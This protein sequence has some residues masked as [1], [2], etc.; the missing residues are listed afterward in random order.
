[1][2]M[3]GDDIFLSS[4]NFDPLE[5]LYGLKMYGGHGEFEILHVYLSQ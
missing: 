5:I 3:V 1:V 4:V 2:G